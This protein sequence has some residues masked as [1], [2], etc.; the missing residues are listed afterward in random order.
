MTKEEAQHIV[1]LIK[2]VKPL[3]TRFQEQSWSVT[4]EA[5]NGRFRYD[6]SRMIEF[7]DEGGNL[8]TDWEMQERFFTED[9][10]VSYFE[11]L[12]RYDVLIRW[13]E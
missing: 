3:R 6:A 7:E 4:Y 5:N 11:K 10:L 13:L 9:Q 12:Y 1:Q 2:A 8:Q